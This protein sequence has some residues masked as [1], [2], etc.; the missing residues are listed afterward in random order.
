MELIT[1]N[2]DLKRLYD[3]GYEIRIVN[4]GHVVIYSVPYLASN[5]ELAYGTLVSVLVLAGDNTAYGPASDHTVHFAGDYPRA[6]DGSELASFAKA[7]GRQ[8]ILPD[9]WTDYTLSA[10]PPGNYRDHHH[11]M[12]TYIKKLRAPLIELGIEAD[13]RTFRP[14]DSIDD[15]P[16]YFPDTNSGRAGTTVINNRVGGQ[17][18]AILGVGGT[19]SYVLDFVA[20][21][22]VK[23]IHPFDGDVMLSHNAFRAPGSPTIDQLRNMPNK[24]TYHAAT[25]SRMHKGIKPHD[26]NMVEARLS[27]LDQFDFVFICM[28]GGPDKQKIIEYLTAKTT[29]FVDV[30]LSMRVHD[31]KLRGQVRTTL[32]TP[33]HA[34][35]LADYLPVTSSDTNKNIY[36]SNA[37]IAEMNALNA[38]RAVE[39]WKRFYNIYDAYETPDHSVYKI[40]NGR[41]VTYAD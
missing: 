36:R 38:C 15:S 18:I 7:G 28:D 25:Y 41:L 22:P 4:N 10:K 35:K 13:A 16:F 14:V 3:D 30:G 21:T 40:R 20:K 6:A 26:Y 37:Q 19:G 17:K 5:N 39:A 1:R 24:A 2:T 29:P 12:T 33:E 31:S 23:E 9:L 8:E 32:V 27:E 11:K 34:E